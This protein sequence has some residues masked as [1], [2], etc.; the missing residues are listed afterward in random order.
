LLRRLV[1][2]DWLLILVAQIRF[3]YFCSDLLLRFVA[4]FV[5][6]ICCSDFKPVLRLG[7]HKCVLMFV[8][9]YWSLRQICWSD[10]LLI[11]FWMVCI[12]VQR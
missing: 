10:M 6:H 2:H 4:Q 3:S 9:S 12:H 8:F 1:A 5:A 7:A 11:R